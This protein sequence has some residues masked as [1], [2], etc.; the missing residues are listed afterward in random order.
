[1]SLVA[2]L[3]E[4]VHDHRPDGSLTADATG[5]CVEWLFAHSGVSVRSHL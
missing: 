1:M 3:E 2:D 5:A 4:F